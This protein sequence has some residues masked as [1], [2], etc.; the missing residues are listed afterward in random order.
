MF[1]FGNRVNKSS[2]EREAV[3]RVTTWMHSELRSRWPTV[4]RSE[5]DVQVMVTEI[6]CN[7]PDCV[8]IETLVAIF[9]QN[10]ELSS[11]ISPMRYSTKIMKPV[12]EVTKVDVVT[13]EL[14]FSFPSDNLNMAMA[15]FHDAFSTLAQT[16]LSP[17]ETKTMIEYLQ[18]QLQQLQASSTST[19]SGGSAVEPQAT[20]T[21]NTANP[22][23]E[24]TR[25]KMKALDISTTV[26]EA[27]VAP[28]NVKS[29]VTVVTMRPA[30]TV[31]TSSSASA[32]NHSI[33]NV[34]SVAMSKSDNMEP[35][36]SS[37]SK[38]NDEGN[39]KFDTKIAENSFKVSVVSDESDTN[40]SLIPAKRDFRE[41]LVAKKQDQHKPTA[42][43]DKEAKRRGCPCCDP[44]NLDH[45]VDKMLFMEYPQM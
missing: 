27:K 37:G 19:S 1:T 14:P 21:T 44:D 12:A 7:E 16:S 39:S 45:L 35:S 40:P 2:Q 29:D 38:G 5:T 10:T 20:V 42:R 18:F 25:V 3:S 22:L 41:T 9:I 28:A 6:Q 8:P 24:V 33:P 23:P 11:L 17:E 15:P 30:T 32:T 31:P 34:T 13:V 4:F 36:S 26:V 43:H